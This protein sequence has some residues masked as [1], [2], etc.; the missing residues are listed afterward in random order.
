MFKHFGPTAHELILRE[1]QRLGREPRSPS[2][3]QREAPGEPRTWSC[4]FAC[5]CVALRGGD[6]LRACRMS[7]SC[8]T[9]KEDLLTLS[10]SGVADSFFLTGTS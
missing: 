1:G 2:S 3:R 4:V 6:L 10:L 5:A 9:I 8:G 7:R